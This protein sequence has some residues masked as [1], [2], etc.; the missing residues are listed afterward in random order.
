MDNWAIKLYDRRGNAEA[1]LSM[2]NE[3]ECAKL[4]AERKKAGYPAPTVWRNGKR[5]AG[6]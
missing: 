4:W 6:Y 2:K 3:S 1:E 5:V